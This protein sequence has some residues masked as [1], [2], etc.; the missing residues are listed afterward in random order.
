MTNRP[1]KS[2]RPPEGTLRKKKVSEM[3]PRIFK[4]VQDPEALSIALDRLIDDC[5][6][7]DGPKG[8]SFKIKTAS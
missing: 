3:K 4:V 1:E 2:N 5:C 7:L 8:G 6:P